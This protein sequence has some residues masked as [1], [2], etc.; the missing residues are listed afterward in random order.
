MLDSQVEMLLL[1]VTWFCPDPAAWPRPVYVG[2]PMGQPLLEGDRHLPPPHH[3]THLP[4]IEYGAE[5]RLHVGD[6]EDP[7]GGGGQ[8]TAGPGE[9][10]AVL[11]EEQGAA[12]GEEPIVLYR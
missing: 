9:E 2:H 11:G 4:R 7:G 12:G 5:L 6:G 3:P 8:V 1:R 10:D